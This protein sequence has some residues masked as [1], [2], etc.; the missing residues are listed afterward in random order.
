[1]SVSGEAPAEGER[2]AKLIARAGLCSRRDAEAWIAARRVAVDGMV[3]ETP[4]VR[5]RAGQRVTVDG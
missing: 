2:I 1:M 4:A 5:V 3:L